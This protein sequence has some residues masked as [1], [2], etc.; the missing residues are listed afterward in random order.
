VTRLPKR[1]KMTKYQTSNPRRKC[2]DTEPMKSGRND[3]N[4]TDVEARLWVEEVLQALHHG[5]TD[6]IDEPGGRRRGGLRGGRTPGR[7]I[8]QLKY[9]YRGG[10]FVV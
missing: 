5:T 3:V 4:H 2:R 9:V 1:R 8:R 10:L 7:E 6:V